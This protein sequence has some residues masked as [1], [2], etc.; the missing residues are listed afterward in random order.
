MET[1][2]PSSI[3]PR[4]N[5]RNTRCPRAARKSA[6]S[7]WTA[8]QIRRPSGCRMTARIRLR[9][10]SSGRQ[11]CSRLYARAPLRNPDRFQVA[12]EKLT[13]L[14]F[15]A[16]RGIS[17]GFKSN[18]QRDSSAKSPPRNDKTYFFSSH[19]SLLDRN[20]AGRMLDVIDQL[21]VFHLRIG[22]ARALGTRAGDL[23]GA[24]GAHDAH[25]PPFAPPAR[26]LAGQGLPQFFRGAFLGKESE[27]ALVDAAGAV[28]DHV[29]RM[30]DKGREAMARGD[31]VH[32]RF[33]Q[34]ERILAEDVEQRIILRGGE[35]EL[36][37]P[38]QKIRHHRTASAPLRLEMGAARKGHVVGEFKCVR[39][40]RVAVHAAGA[41]TF[42]A[43]L[44]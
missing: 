3:Q 38:A 8:A 2:S 25:L 28:F 26:R 31:G 14:S 40:L 42:G 44:F 15:R 6:T 33:P 13:F 7:R 30:N 22:Q 5:S 32:F 4:K 27:K 34:V 18:T 17:P 21:A 37:Q 24:A 36:E 39:P 35:R 16:K 9:G 43:P 41:K 11:P 19:L 29:I 20:A 10:F 1:A 12:A 23:P